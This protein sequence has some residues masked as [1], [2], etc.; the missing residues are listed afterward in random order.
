[1][2]ASNVLKEKRERAKKMWPHKSPGERQNCCVPSGGFRS[3]LLSREPRDLP[4]VNCCSGCPKE[5][6]E[7]TRNLPVPSQSSVPSGLY[8]GGKKKRRQN[9]MWLLGNVEEMA[10]MF[11]SRAA[12][13]RRCLQSQ[14][15]SYWGPT[16][17]RGLSWAK[18][19]CRKGGWDSA[20][21]LC[22]AT[23]PSPLVWM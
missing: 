4:F 17:E 3:G 15:S 18:G 20:L 12:L 8:Y 22:P 9:K 19:S 5:I 7:A 13:N 1:M 11:K 23:A 14:G 10:E 21:T 2:P 6:P 16:W